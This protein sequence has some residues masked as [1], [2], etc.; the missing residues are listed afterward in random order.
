[1][2]SPVKVAKDM[3]DLAKHVNQ[4][5]GNFEPD[6][7]EDHYETA[8][9][10]LINEK[11]AGRVIRPKAW[12]KGENVVD[13][14]EALRWPRG[15]VGEGSQAGQEA[16][17]GRPRTEGNADADRRQEAGEGSCG[18]ESC[19]GD[20]AEVGLNVRLGFGPTRARGCGRKIALRMPLIGLNASGHSS[21]AAELSY[22][23]RRDASVGPVDR[24]GSTAPLSSAARL[25][26]TA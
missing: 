16:E 26:A 6:K 5:A 11:R 1:M 10:D 24:V 8:W 25:S 3:L 13:L 21:F 12:P 7:F 2:T 18:K 20:A 17:K 4:K 14:M 19:G 9:V 15:R 22:A 23:Y